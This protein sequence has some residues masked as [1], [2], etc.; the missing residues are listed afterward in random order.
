MDCKKVKEQINRVLDGFEIND[1]I[2]LSH[3]KNCRKCLNEYNSVVKIKSSLY[4]QEKIKIPD[5]FN[6]MVWNKIG[7]PRPSVFDFIKKTFIPKP[8][9]AAAATVVVLILILFGISFFKNKFFDVKKD[10]MVYN[11]NK[12]DKTDKKI[13]SVEKKADIKQEAKIS[14]VETEKKQEIVALKINEEEQV[15]K[16]MEKKKDEEV[17]YNTFVR[18]PEDIKSSSA[19][20]E[21]V[22]IA[23]IKKAP[24]K[25]DTTDIRYLKEDFKVLNNVINPTKGEKVII[26]YKIQGQCMVKIAVYDRN[27]ELVQNLVKENKDKGVYESAWD[28]KDAKGNITGAGI[29]FIY[30][31]T[32]IVEKKIKVLVV[33]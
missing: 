24:D 13:A 23:E 27:G 33:K 22:A 29:Y 26:R 3:I 20:G 31:K 21:K 8:V 18:L 5:N 11:I 9:F 6:E 10:H 7:E 17:V 12:E 30:L 19:T 16:G 14:K 2:V 1:T 25:I 32:D 28:G 4:T 15:I